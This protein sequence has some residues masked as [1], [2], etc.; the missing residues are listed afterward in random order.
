MSICKNAPTILPPV[1]ITRQN[2]RSI[3]TPPYPTVDFKSVNKRF[4]SNV[5]SPTYLPIHGCFEDADAYDTKHKRDKFPFGFAL[6]FLT[7]AGPITVSDHVFHGYKYKA[8]E[9]WILNAQFPEKEEKRNQRTK[10]RR[11]RQRG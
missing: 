4:L 7:N 9:G 10:M 8:G 6:G 5:P 1:S 2:I 3:A 11:K